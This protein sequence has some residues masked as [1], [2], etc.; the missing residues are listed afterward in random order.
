MLTMEIH[1][2]QHLH[3]RQSIQCRVRS[4]IHRLQ[5]HPRA[6]VVI[7]STRNIRNRASVVKSRVKS[8]IVQGL[9]IMIKT[10]AGHTSLI[11]AR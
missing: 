3:L 9:V 7:K 5:R 2:Q 4:E 11:D 1:S 8:E 10:D 6:R